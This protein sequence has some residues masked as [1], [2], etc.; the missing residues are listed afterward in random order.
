MQYRDELTEREIEILGLIDKGF[1]NN[2]ISKELTLSLHT[3]KWYIKQIFA[4]LQVKRRTQAVARAKDLGI[5]GQ[6][7]LSKNPLPVPL[8]PMMGRAKEIEELSIL[9]LR[10]DTRLLSI[11]G[12]G[13]SGK[14]HLALH[15]ASELEDHFGEH[16]HYLALAGMQ[17]V[18]ELFHGLM[19]LCGLENLSP[20]QVIERLILKFNQQATLLI[21]DN[22]EHL[23]GHLSFL[24]ELIIHA[25]QLRILVTSR[26]QLHMMGETRFYLQGIE[27]ESDASSLF[28][29]IAKQNCTHFQVNERNNQMIA[30]IC[31]LV[32]NLP[33]AIILAA[34]WTQTLSISEI[35]DELEQD[36]QLLKSSSA[37]LPERHQSMQH[38]LDYSWHLLRSDEQ[39]ALMSL[40]IFE[41]TFTRDALRHITCI[42]LPMLST[43]I[44][45]SLVLQDRLTTR[46]YLHELIR[47]YLLEKLSTQVD[48][49]RHLEQAFSDYYLNYLQHYSVLIK[50]KHQIEALNAIDEAYANI[51]QAWCHIIAN[52][53]FDHITPVLD[54][55]L[56]FEIK[57]R[58]REGL[59][60]FEHLYAALPCPKHKLREPI[61]EIISALK[62]RTGQLDFIQQTLGSIQ[63]LSASGYITL[64]ST[65]I[66][67]AQDEE[68]EYYYREAL[69]LATEN[70]DVWYQ[71]MSAG[72]LAYL[73]LKQK[74]YSEAEEFL[75]QEQRL[76][77]H[78]EDYYR[79]AFNLCHQGELARDKHL[80]RIAEA[81]YLQSIDIS[82]KTGHRQLLARGYQRLGD[83]A[84]I[85]GHD[86]LSLKY[87]KLAYETY[88]DIHHLPGMFKASCS[89]VEI[90]I[91]YGDVCDVYDYL[92]QID[93]IAQ[94][95]SVKN[96][97]TGWYL[98]AQ[99][100]IRQ[101]EITEAMFVLARIY[102]HEDCT[103]F[104]RRRTQVQYEDIRL[105]GLEIFP[106]I[107]DVEFGACPY[108]STPQTIDISA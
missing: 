8:M 108:E 98:Y 86:D 107:H 101:Q 51:K 85:E 68:A 102:Q 17:S 56:F 35:L 88:A 72:H 76:L 14:T 105:T 92:G 84:D 63:G 28:T 55:W 21:L 104:L 81:F 16:I 96:Q 78:N 71:C 50:G 58:F 73:K 77:Q 66:L 23:S 2:G 49:T 70:Q 95:I 43:L 44:G 19:T 91:D 106:A 30:R 61:L 54:F 10:D 22:C 62:L 6:P 53:Q 52:G 31:I 5:I 99:L 11:I 32:G 59:E 60:L 46:Y 57:G 25:P 27:L 39:K 26:E 42:N 9:L 1:S 18:D 3:V 64:G 41:G 38:V 45:K 103:D 12:L 90:L 48:F 100:L 82:M 7:T 24:N 47:Q 36:F 20:S 69:N 33:L 80:Y 79:R 97:I 40:A 37:N 94:E 29:H 75:L 65:C 93:R 15:L 4:K 87:L 74:N 89:I 13:G 83:L 34:S 67:K